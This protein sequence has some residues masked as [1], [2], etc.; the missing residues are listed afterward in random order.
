MNSSIQNDQI[1]STLLQKASELRSL[2]NHED[3]GL[4]DEIDAS[5]D[6]K[7]CT[8]ELE[9][10]YRSLEQYSRS[11]RD[12]R[13]LALVGHYSAGKSS[14]INSLL[15]NEIRAIDLHPTDQGVTFISHS[16]N[17]KKILPAESQGDLNV[18]VSL[19]EHEILR[20]T[21][22]IDTPGTGDPSKV[23]AMVKDI[24][25]LASMLLYLI[26]ATN[27][28]DESDLPNM[29]RIFEELNHIPFK[30]VITR[31]DVFKSDK[32]LPLSSTNVNELDQAQ[33][34]AKFIARLRSEGVAQDVTPSDLIFIDNEAQFGLQDLINA[35][36]KCDID[37]SKIHINTLHF[38]MRRL[39]ATQTRIVNWSEKI[40]D[41]VAGLLQKASENRAKFDE[42]TGISTDTLMRLLST[43]HTDLVKRIRADSESVDAWMD[44]NAQFLGPNTSALDAFIS[45]AI[46]AFKTELAEELVISVKQEAGDV[47]KKYAMRKY[48]L[49]EADPDWRVFDNRI[50]VGGVDV[51]VEDVEG[52]LNRA[53]VSL[54][55]RIVEY[56][57]GLVSDVL[58][59]ASGLEHRLLEF[60]E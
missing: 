60:D 11:E 48:D 26:N 8:N 56:W 27:P 43:N 15:A 13:Y 37:T 12:M 6:M 45:N 10:I 29:K 55:D 53:I 46:S 40:D 42:N 36:I 21:V 35:A 23:G 17:A 9:N 4:R 54:S 31:S 59:E 1:T 49:H 19:I 22:L 44:Q 39:K 32:S 33:F 14:T 57:E 7:A 51:S 16:N 28:F 34:A 58:D 3:F 24:L 50:D 52:A 30:F 25:P 5:A 18:Q 20:E 2:V 47:F 41:S 38:Y